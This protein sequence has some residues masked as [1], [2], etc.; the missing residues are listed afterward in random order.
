MV[1]DNY[2]QFCQSVIGYSHRV[3]NLPCQDACKT[4][5]NEETNLMIIAVADGHGSEPLSQTG[6][7]I[8]V[9]S[10]C[11][12]IADFVK[13]L[14]NTDIIKSFK[15]LSKS[16]YCGI[17]PEVKNNGFAISKPFYV[18]DSG[19]QKIINEK[20]ITEEALNEFSIISDFFNA[21]SKLEKFIVYDWC[22]KVT[23]DF[24]N[25]KDKEPEKLK[26]YNINE[27]DFNNPYH[28]YGT[29]LLAAAISEEYWF[30]IQIGDGTCLALFDENNDY[31][32]FKQIN[33]PI[34]DD[35]RCYNNITTSI[36][37]SDSYLEFRHSVGTK[38]P[39]AIFLGSDGI[40]NSFSCDNRKQELQSLQNFYIDLIKDFSEDTTKEKR[41]ENLS[42]K[43]KNLTEDYSGDDMA[44]AGLISN[45]W[46]KSPIDKTL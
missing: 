36:C 37:D 1:T 6:S 45:T 14:N 30:A 15:S 19:Y 41:N 34:P 24:S 22:T 8:V 27:S 33:Q 44:I 31:S 25:I 10:A 42:E 13:E 18:N 12:N 17:N 46:L 3:R 38:L 40:E 35:E 2:Y 5:S 16:I 21:L 32:E 39:Q 20:L 9:E 28:L 43:L 4:I 23:E 11:K 7:K 29:T 26:E